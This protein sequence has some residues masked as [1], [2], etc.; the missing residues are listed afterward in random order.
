[1][2]FEV[3]DMTDALLEALQRRLAEGNDPRTVEAIR[4]A[5]EA[6]QQVRGGHTRWG[7]VCEE[8][9]LMG[10]A[11]REFQL[12]MR[13]DQADGVALERLAEHY[14]ERGDAVRAASLFER[15]LQTNPAHQPWL[16]SLA[17]LLRGTPEWQQVRQ[18]VERAVAAGLPEDRAAQ[19]LRSGDGGSCE[20][21]DIPSALAD[22]SQEPLPPAPT[23]AD[24]IRFA[25]LFAGREDVYARQW[26]RPADGQTGYTP[27]HEPLTPAVIRNHLLGTFTAGVYPIRLDQTATWFAVDLDIRRPALDEARRDAACARELRD[28]TRRTGL[29]ILGTLCELGLDPLFENSGYKGRHYWVFLEEPE[30]AKVL[31]QCGRLLLARL[32]RDLAT[33][34][35]LEFFPK[36]PHRG[37]K[38]LGNLIKLPLGVHRRTGYRSTLLD[39]QGKQID[40]PLELLQNVRRLPRQ[41]LYDL[42]GRLKPLASL[43][44][45]DA[46]ED[47]RSSESPEELNAGMV[48]VAAPAPPEL[49]PPWT[50][51]DFEADPKIRHL[52]AQCPVLA[53]LKS[54]VDNYRRLT[55]DEQVV[56]IHS[57]GHVPGGPQA[58]NYLLQKCVDVAPDSLMQSRLKG[59]PISC[60]KIRKRIGHITR[61]VKCRCA[62]EFAPTHYPT[63]V[64]HLETL[65]AE[66]PAEPARQQDA[67]SGPQT[68]ARRYGVLDRQRREIEQQ[69]RQMHEAICRLL[70]GRSDRTLLCDDGHYELSGQD[71]VETLVWVPD[72]RGAA[73]PPGDGQ[74]SDNPGPAEGS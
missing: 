56:L 30:E 13:D 54:Q 65:P 5:V 18:A 23:D 60:P 27:V 62:F 29:A 72:D 51:A 53:E 73:T 12:A 20:A 31:H 21:A 39:Q 68:L 32:Q 22:A 25:S 15:L 61:K 41:A 43:V 66:T 71:G 40:R 59:N 38:G 6:R 37:G 19:L 49:A 47:A 70:H 42:I 69:W 24:C 1:M 46:G 74:D 17:E 34:F 48:A 36:Q 10:L 67:A 28:L 57:L 50:E 11:F 3:A 58:V 8:A 33:E 26:H 55:H 2:T 14:Q 9:G 16:Q 63:P 52:L 44:P 4:A 7:L 45:L 35:A 64:L